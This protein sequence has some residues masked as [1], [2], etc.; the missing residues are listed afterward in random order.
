MTDTE[1]AAEIALLREE[2]LE[3][4][5]VLDMERRIYGFDSPSVRRLEEQR[6]ETMARWNE[7]KK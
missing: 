4:L 1:K 3:L 6:D 7:L 5:V 2:L